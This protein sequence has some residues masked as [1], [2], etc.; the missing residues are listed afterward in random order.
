MNE[1][2][3]NLFKSKVG[4]YKKIGSFE[5]DKLIKLLEIELSK[6]NDLNLK[7]C[8][9]RKKDIAYNHEHIKHCFIMVDG[10]YFKRRE[11]ISFNNDGFIG[12]AGWASSENCKPINKAFIKWVESL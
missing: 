10:K 12:F 6:P 4:D 8:S 3:R 5:I 11:A 9:I 1:I 7:I 2:C